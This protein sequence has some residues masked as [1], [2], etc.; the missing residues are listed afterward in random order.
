MIMM[1]YRNSVCIDEDH[2]L[3]IEAAEAV[4][5]IAFAVHSVVISNTLPASSETVYLN[6]VTKEKESLCVELTVLGFR[7]GCF[8]IGRWLCHIG[9]AQAGSA[10]V[11]V[12][13]SRLE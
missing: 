1:A 12:T 9:P 2:I 6:L 8:I 13:A 11:V 3:H 10:N 4:K 7:V 5:E